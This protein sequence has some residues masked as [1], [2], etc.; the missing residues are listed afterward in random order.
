MSWTVNI[1]SIPSDDAFFYS[2]D[3]DAD[4]APF[5]MVNRMLI[6]NRVT[7]VND[8]SLNGFPSTF[9]LKQNYPNPFNPST[10]I[11]YFLPERA[12]V[13]L[14]VYNTTGQIITTLVDQ[15][16]P[17]GNYQII[18]DASSLVTGVYFVKMEAGSFNSVRKMML[19]R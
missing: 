14:N 7:G 19:I 9:L 6:I 5:K 2:I 8:N 3:V 10:T 12:H 4:N 17:A 18:F 16:K 15:D 11:E 1:N 13:R